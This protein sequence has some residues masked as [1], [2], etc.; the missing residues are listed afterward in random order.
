MKESNKATRFAAS[1][2]AVALIVSACGGDDAATEDTTAEDTTAEDTAT[3]PADDS[4]GGNGTL[5]WAHEQEPGDLHLD[6]PEN[7]LTITA[8]IRTGMWEG[9]FGVSSKTEYYPRLLASEPALASADDG[10]VT[11]TYTL[12]DG[13][14]W[15]DGDDLTSD[16]VKYTFDMLMARN[17]ADEYV[18]LL[19]DRTGLDTITAFNVVSPTE[20]SVTWSAFF[21][22]WKALFGEIHPKHVFP[23]DPAEAAAAENDALRTWSYNDTVLPS[24][25]PLVFSEWNKGVSMSLVRNDSYHGSTSPDAVNTGVAQ[26]G[27]VE[28]NFVPDTDAQINALKAGEADVI[29]TQ[30]QLAFEEFGT[31]DDFVVAS[32]AGPIFEHWGLNLFNKHLKRPEVREALALAMD[33]GAVMEGLYTPLFGSSLPA[34]GL[35]NVYWMSNQSDYQDATSDAGYGKGDIAAAKAKLESAGYVLGADGIYAH[36]TD[37]ALSLRVGTTGGNKLRELQQQLLQAKFKEAGIDIVIYN[38]PGGEY[39]DAQPFNSDA[40]ACASSGGTKGD[41][42]KWDIAQFAWVGGPWPGGQSAVLRTGAGSNIYGFANAEFDAKAD[43]CDGTVDD[44]VRA[45]CYNELNLYAVTLQKDAKTGLFMIP[46][47][48]KP[49]F[50]AVSKIRLASYGVAPDANNA[51]PLLNVA[52]FKKN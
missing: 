23:A 25:G 21:A 20:F 31:N 49:S 14:T 46:L 32:S 12:R 28:I 42:N 34:E 8:W 36:P 51:G 6:D 13:L 43:E 15:S 45:A 39:W 47:T 50:Y 24:S 52:D 41:C 40:L 30:P 27:C 2:F 1:L 48:Q 9:L 35:G 4:C 37:G 7:G 19:G 44:A 10:S 17:S 16:D 26:V 38:Q 5:I 33:K 11:A 29:M 22:G 3:G 18:Y